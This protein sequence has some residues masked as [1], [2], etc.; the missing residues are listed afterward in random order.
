MTLLMTRVPRRFVAGC[1]MT[2]QRRSMVTAM[3]SLEQGYPSRWVAKVASRWAT[4]ATSRWRR[5]EESR[6]RGDDVLMPE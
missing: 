1:R 4:K 3:S 5:T 6:L 2:V